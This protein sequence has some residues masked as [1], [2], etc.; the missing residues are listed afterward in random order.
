MKP[1]SVEYLETGF[2][3]IYIYVHKVYETCKGGLYF[4]IYYAAAKAGHK[5]KK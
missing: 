2:R 3:N 5:D 1:L 4:Y